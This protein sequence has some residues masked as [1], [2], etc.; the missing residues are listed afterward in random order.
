VIHAL[1]VVSGI[2]FILWIIG[3]ASSWAASTAWTLFVLA[4]VL[5]AIWLVA[6]IGRGGGRRVVT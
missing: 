1:L 6:S 5:L 3:L 4:V 2:L